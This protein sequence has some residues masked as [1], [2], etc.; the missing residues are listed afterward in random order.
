[1]H[2][3]GM[4]AVEAFFGGRLAPRCVTFRSNA[5]SRS[6]LKFCRACFGSLEFGKRMYKAI[7]C[8]RFD[9]KRELR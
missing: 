5:F 4:S 9:W 7:E 8:R 1:M 6:S 2:A 3:G